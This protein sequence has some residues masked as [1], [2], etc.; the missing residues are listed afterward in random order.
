MP[1]TV[2]RQRRLLVHTRLASRRRWLLSG[3]AVLL[4]LPLYASLTARILLPL[5]V[6]GMLGAAIGTRVPQAAMH[7]HTDQDGVP[8]MRLSCNIPMDDGTYEALT[9]EDQCLTT[10]SGHDCCAT[11]R[12]FVQVRE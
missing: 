1:R 2:P 9:P 11:V 4:E 6:A 5:A 12:S 7:A 3:R 10:P 8:V